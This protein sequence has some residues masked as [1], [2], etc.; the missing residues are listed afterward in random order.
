MLYFQKK[1]SI[2]NLCLKIS[3]RGTQNYLQI[4][5]KQSVF[6]GSYLKVSL[7]TFAAKET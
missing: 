6:H 1:L 3:V 4:H 7:F 5:G 2:G